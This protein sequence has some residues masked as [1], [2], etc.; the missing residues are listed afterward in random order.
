MGYW[1]RS[2]RKRKRPKLPPAP[3]NQSETVE[4]IPSEIRYSRSFNGLLRESFVRYLR[5]GLYQQAQMFRMYGM[6]LR[7]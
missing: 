1:A 4:I 2:E 6:R 3:E 7:R 5:F